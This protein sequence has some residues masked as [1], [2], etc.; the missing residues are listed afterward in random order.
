MRKNKGHNIWRGVGLF[1]LGLY[2]LVAL[3][4]FTVVQSYIG[5]VAGSRL[6]K[7]WGGKVK[8]GAMHFSPISHVILNDVELISPSNDTIFKGEHIS[9]RFKHFPFHDHSLKFDHVYLRNGRYHFESILKPDGKHCTNLQYIIDHYASDKPK[10]PHTTPFCV[11]VGQLRLRNIDYIQD[12]PH[13]GPRQYANGVDIPH[14]R[15]YGTSAYFRNVTVIGDS[16]STR[17]VS[18]STTEASGLHVVDLSADVVVSRNGISATNFDLQTGDS[19]VFMDAKLMYHNW[20]KDYCNEVNHDVVLKEGTEVN[21][22]DAS[23]WAPTLWGIDNKVRVQ[24]HIHGPVSDMYADGL[25]ASFG[26]NSDLSLDA[27]IEGL[28]KINITTIDAEIH[29]LHTNYADLAAVKHPEGITMKLPELIRQMCIIDMAASL[30]G[31]MKDC[32]AEVELNSMIGDLTAKASLNYDTTCHDF[33]YDADLESKVMGLRTLLPNEWVSR[34]GFHI[35]VQGTGFDPK[36]MEASVE[37]RLYNTIFKGNDIDRTA[38]TADLSKQHLSADI[39]LKD[40]LID[41]D[42]TASADLSDKRYY[43]DLILNHAHLSDL[44]LVK[45]DSS[46]VLSTQVH[47]DIHGG[48]LDDLL[49]SVSAKNTHCSIGHRNISLD[50]LDILSEGFGGLR[51]L[52]LNCDWLDMTMRGYFKYSVLPSLVRDFCDR[53]VPTYYNPYRTTDSADLSEL[54]SSNFDLDMTWNDEKGTFQNI[55]PGL[56]IAD[57]SSF[58]GNYNYGEALKMV[59]VSD[60]IS[61]NNITLNDIGFNGGAAGTT[62]RLNIRSNNIVLGERPLLE[63]IYLTSGLGGDLSTLNLRWDDNA[64]TTTNEG[65]IEMFLTSSG[66]DNRLVITKPNFYIMGQRWSLSCP[67][68][69]FFNNDRLLADNLK[70]YGYEQSVSLK[71]NISKSDEDVVKMAFD[72]FSLGSLC[73][74]LIPNGGLDVQGTLDGLFSLK[75][76][77]KTPYF[78]ANLVVDNCSINGLDAGVVNIESN[79]VADSAKLLV[80]LVAEHNDNGV[81]HRPI[82]VHGNMLLGKQIPTM[83]F[84]VDLDDVELKTA[85]PMLVNI[86]SNLGG[87]LGGHIHVHGT[88]KEPLIDGTLGIKEGGISLTPT[89]A[90]YH[91]DDTLSIVHNVLTLKDFSIKDNQNNSAKVNGDIRFSQGKV[92]LNLDLETDRLLVLDKEAGDDFYG[93]VFASAQGSITGPANQL[94]ISANTTALSGSDLYVPIDNQKEVN[95]NEFITF[96]NPNRTTQRI[97][98]RPAVVKSNGINMQLSV[99][100]TPGM[101]LHLP[102]DFDQVSAN[103]TAVGNGDIQVSMRDGGQ[104]NIL[105]DYKFSSGNI[106]LSLIQLI[107]KNFA[108]QEGSTLNFPGSINDTR[109]NINAAYSLRTNLSSLMGNTSINASDSYV[110]VQDII[111]LSGTM[112]DPTIKFD[113]RLPNSEQSV[114]DQVFTYIDRNNEMEMLN[115]SISLL[116][117][118]RF[119]PTGASNEGGL[120]EGINGMSLLT[121]SASSIVSNLVKIVDVDFKYQAATNTTA[122]QIDVG[123]SKQWNK[124]YF[125]STFGYGNNTN[126]ID[127]NMSNVIVGD[128]EMGYKFNPYFNFYGFHRSNSSYYTR[129]ELPYKQGIGVKLTKDFDSFRDL[130]P[131]KKKKVNDTV[132]RKTTPI[133]SN[134]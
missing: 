29:H 8:I 43:A 80:D 2:V 99:S 82:A 3:L 132:Q 32:Q 41:L 20:M 81:L 94:R 54:Y 45:A 108:I 62:Y 66:Q 134:K 39:V 9:C 49:G 17:I 89:G 58:H 97:Q 16:I 70:I 22:R 92:M 91:F 24:G 116:V 126:D 40:T 121:S 21:L 85:E 46:V 112:E 87:L 50:K 128:V 77:S 79:Y 75:G 38:I 88:Q 76:L 35:T 51:R 105:G 69:I 34:T 93:K 28:P 14:M 65:D 71:A 44:H 119:S 90:D 84:N 30:H 13:E 98:T 37:G 12:L 36:T 102:M 11:E 95:E 110:P 1:F 64:P 124:L 107:S 106:N 122:G 130:F 7:E 6:S 55:V 74:M 25:T 103:I 52:N 15:Y 48:T 125:E 56:K 42:L 131:H 111:T 61:F 78:D 63:N 113:I 60:A 68:G 123:I 47:A 120:T 19:R 23:F 96:Y 73:Q 26:E 10:K 33:M 5:A 57:G 53:Y 4:N 18:F 109:F 101:K 27:H 114:V 67:N 129:T 72:D 59:F 104:P 100:V 86:V 83:D 115:Q 133:P 117:L 118:G 127:P 31:G